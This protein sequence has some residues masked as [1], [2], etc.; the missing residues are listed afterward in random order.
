MFLKVLLCNLSVYMGLNML[1]KKSYSLFG[2]GIDYKLK[3]AFYLM[4][5]LPFF[6]TIYLVSNYMLPKVG[7][8]LDVLSVI[9]LS[10]FISSFGFFVLKEMFRRFAAVNNS[11]K[12]IAAG[13]LSCSVDVKA[14][15]EI[16]ELGRSLNV[17]TDRIRN[18]MEELKD[19]GERTKQINTDIQR[20]VIVL[21]G[22]LQIG[23]L[24]TQGAK[25]EDI[26][27]ISVE[28]ARLLAGSDLSYLLL[29]ND[30]RGFFEVKAADG[31]NSD[32]LLKVRFDPRDE[33]TA[34]MANL[35]KP[36]FLDKGH[37]ILEKINGAFP[38]ELNL[39]SSLITPVHLKGRL[40]AIMGIGN[41]GESEA[42]EKPCV[43]LMD[44]VAKQI[45]IGIEND[46]LSHRIE[47]LEIKDPLTGL[48]NEAF[49]RSRL[50]EEIK[51]A[52]VYQRPCSLAV[53]HIDRFNV[54]HKKFG[55]LNSESALKKAGFLVKSLVT[56]I[57]RVGRTSD[58][59][60]AIILPEKNKRQARDIAEN[61]RKEIE[62]A[63]GEEED[64][65][66]KLTLSGGV[67]ENPL[68]GV[69]AEDLFAKARDLVELSGKQ[70]GNRIVLSREKT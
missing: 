17:L 45:A 35:S 27:R 5:V 49:M 2:Q 12:L 21:S 66:K 64:Q 38:G 70:G 41:T 3:I 33:L 59:E 18:N 67:S 55:L 23:S 29:W 47:A 1:N 60:F 34:K 24:I 4:S 58:D 28:K 8:K 52:I 68:D 62:F 69:N 16:D 10:I 36:L 61:I 22:L 65:D 13:D 51:R 40:V 25:I 15:D 46:A 30:A 31:V 63:F 20:H 19:Y 7:F 14:A 44:I 32:Y 43:E 54:Y 6:V 48:Y 39:R 26:I 53:L 37:A 50:Q 42:F 11:A 56:D 57:D 9:I